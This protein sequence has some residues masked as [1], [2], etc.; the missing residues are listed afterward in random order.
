MVRKKANAKVAR[1]KTKTDDVNPFEDSVSE[2][3]GA[4]VISMKKEDNPFEDASGLEDVSSTDLDVVSHQMAQEKRDTETFLPPDLEKL[5]LKKH[6]TDLRIAI[7]Q[8][9][10]KLGRVLYYIKCN[11]SYVDWGHDTFDKYIESEEPGGKRRLKYLT[12][13]HDW[14]ENE[15]KDQKKIAA[16][17]LLGWSKAAQVRS[18]V[19]SADNQEEAFDKW[20]EKAQELPL[21]KLIESVK[22]EKVQ[23]DLENKKDKEENPDV[24]APVTP[25]KQHPMSFNFFAEQYATVSD[26]LKLAEKMTNSEVKSNN[27]TLICQEFLLTTEA[28]KDHKEAR[29]KWLPRLEDMLRG[30]IVFIDSDTEEVI[31]GAELLDG[32]ED[33]E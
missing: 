18:A 12:D 6:V 19:K 7:D 14:F 1:T 30:K 32:D 25:D 8:N 15:V 20:M 16:I 11:S 9:C 27:L 21:R 3:G 26:A 22:E 33:E 2:S 23:K 4:D 24:T 29:M 28:G 5:D 13:L 31:Y 17:Q 10:F